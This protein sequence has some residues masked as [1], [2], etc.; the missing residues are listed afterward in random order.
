MSLCPR[1]CEEQVYRD[2]PPNRVV[3][4]GAAYSIPTLLTSSSPPR[5]PFR[6]IRMKGVVFEKQGDQPKVVDYLEKPKP[7]P[8]QILV[9]SL[10]TAINPV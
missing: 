1:Y 3:R 5:S 8:D 7:G 2:H 4:V 9:K 6:T 10:W